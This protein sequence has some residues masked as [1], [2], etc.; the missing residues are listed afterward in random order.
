MTN[1][2]T[3]LINVGIDVQLASKF[4]GSKLVTTTSD[5]MSQN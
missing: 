5:V 2:F 1:T 4:S 3:L